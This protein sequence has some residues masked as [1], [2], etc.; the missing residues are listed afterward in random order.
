M[1]F[2]LRPL[3][4]KACEKILRTEYRTDT[5]T[6]SKYLNLKELLKNVYKIFKFGWVFGHGVSSKKYLSSVVPTP[7]SLPDTALD[8]LQNFIFNLKSSVIFSFF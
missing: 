6:F 1:I 2:F 3:S 7:E 4:G 8:C 5:R